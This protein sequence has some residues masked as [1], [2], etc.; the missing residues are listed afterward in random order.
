MTQHDDRLFSA[1]LLGTGLVF[2]VFFALYD[3]VYIAVDSPSYISMDISREPVY[4][5]L[6]AILRTIFASA[7]E[8]FYLQVMV[9]LQSIL[10]AFAAW[11]LA[12]YLYRRLC[13]PRPLTLLIWALPLMVSLL[14]RF[15]AQRGS[16]YSNS[17]LTEGLC[18][19]LYLIAFRFLLEYC[20]DRTAK[21]TAWC[22]VL[23][24]V[25]YSTRKQ[26]LIILAM[27][28]LCTLV[29]ALAGRTGSGRPVTGLFFN[30]PRHNNEREDAQGAGPE[31]RSAA[32]QNARGAAGAPAPAQRLSGRILRGLLAAALGAVLVLGANRALDLGYNYVV[33]GEAT[34]HTSDSRFVTTMAFYTAERTDAQYIEDEGIR[35][36]FL[37]IYDI[38][39][40]QGYL[41]DSAGE[42]WLSRVT[43]FGDHYDNI[44][45]DT[46]WP[47]IRS[48]VTE[49]YADEDGNIDSVV[50]NEEADDVMNVINAAVMPHN[51]GKLLQC[52]FDNLLSGLVTT[53][54][55]RK[56]VLILYSALVYVLYL[57]MLFACMARARREAGSAAKKSLPGEESLSAEGDLTADVSPSAEGNRTA[58]G[59]KAPSGAETCTRPELLWG[60]SVAALLIALSIL[61]NVGV[62]SLVIFAQTRYTIYNMPLFYTG[63][64]LM[65]YALFAGRRKN[66]HYGTKPGQS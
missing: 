39:E 21:S 16:M 30:L 59:E 50:L 27:W 31:L 1:L 23:A 44:Q 35:A 6:L 46:M 24:F 28:V 3:G 64:L 62:V 25:M 63:L 19:P 41:M 18:I 60:V 5:M 45:I 55:Q 54:A 52:F 56:S 37:E 49:L 26:M 4:P 14:C 29:M 13:L 61:A 34:T 10:A 57:T 15:A 53:A 40:E 42:G 66:S 8:T 36:L 17:I 38:C 48:Y 65:A 2:Y 20:L 32:H 51:V 12:M 11:I 9:M 33:R 22:L 7:G 58:E 43:H 47:M